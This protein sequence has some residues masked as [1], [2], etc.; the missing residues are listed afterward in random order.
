M[1]HRLL[2]V[3]LWQPPIIASRLAAYSWAR[4]DWC[5]DMANPTVAVPGK[6]GR[7]QPTGVLQYRDLDVLLALVH[8]WIEKGQD[9]EGRVHCEIHEL[10]RWMGYAKVLTSAPY[11]EIHTSIHRLRYTR[12]MI[13]RKDERDEVIADRSRFDCTLL[14]DLSSTK[15]ALPGD[16]SLIR[17]RLSDNVMDLMRDGSQAI[18]LDVYAHLVRHPATRRLPLARVLWVALSRWRQSDGSLRFRPGWLADRYADMRN[19]SEMHQGTKIYENAYNERSRLQ[20]ALVGLAKTGALGLSTSDDGWV[21][22]KYRVPH[23]LVRLRD[24]PR[25][26]RLL[27][28]DTM[29]IAD[30]AARGEPPPTPRL[31]EHQVERP[32]ATAWWWLPG[33]PGLSASSATAAM[34]SSG[35]GDLDGEA[36][37][38]WVWWS[39]RKGIDGAA[40]ATAAARWMTR[41]KAGREA[42][43]QVTVRQQ[44]AATGHYAGGDPLKQAAR[45][46]RAALTPSKG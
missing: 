16:A 32:A 35:M 27:R 25:Q 1:P 36:L 45:E 5:M 17:T 8:H 22:G 18:D 2:E 37:A 43:N 29:A 24:A 26:T 28:I 20:R 9:P 23:G 3:P 33:I 41:A 40:D 13:Y 30:A 42:W 34:E 10:M 31:V 7:R 38:V 46:M 12:V 21:T 15:Q 14:A 19:Q 39:T 44:I 6:T 11:A 4:G